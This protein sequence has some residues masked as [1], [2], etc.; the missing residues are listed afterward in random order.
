MS[1]TGRGEPSS[2]ASGNDDLTD[3]LARPCSLPDSEYLINARSEALVA[4]LP[5][6]AAFIQFRAK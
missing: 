2:P 5:T 6:T 3:P 4:I 1:A